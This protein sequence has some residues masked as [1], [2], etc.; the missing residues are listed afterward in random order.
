MDSSPAAAL[1]AERRLQPIKRKRLVDSLEDSDT[2]KADRKS[3][4]KFA[5]SPRVPPR[6]IV[7]GKARNSESRAPSARPLKI[8]QS[9]ATNRKLSMSPSLSMSDWQ[10]KGRLKQSNGSTNERGETGAFKPKEV[11]T[12]EAF[13]IDFCNSNGCPTA[14][15]DLMVQ[16][17]KEGSFPGQEW[18]KKKNFWQNVHTI[19]PNRDR[20]SVYRF[21]KRHFQASG[22]KPHEWTNEQEDELVAL[23]QQYGPKW[24]V[25]AEMLG[26]SSDDVVQRWKNRL[27][28][29]ATMNTGPWSE[30]ELSALQGALQSAWTKMKAESYDVGR[31]IYEMDESLISWGAVSD[32]MEHSRSRQQCADKW[33]RLK[34]K[35][36]RRSMS[37]SNSRNTTPLGTP[38]TE[39]FTKELQQLKNYKSEAYVNFDTDDSDGQEDGA[40]GSGKKSTT[41]HTTMKQ[42]TKEPHETSKPPSADE[43]SKHSDSDESDSSSSSSSAS[44]SETEP[45][46]ESSSMLNNKSKP[47]SE[48][49]SE[50]ESDSSA[51]PTAKSNEKKTSK[52]TATTTETTSSSSGSNSDSDSDSSSDS[53]ESAQKHAVPKV[54]G[55]SNELTNSHEASDSSSEEEGSDTDDSERADTASAKPQSAKSAI[56]EDPHSTKRKR[57]RSPAQEDRNPD[58]KR[59]KVKEPPSPTRSETSSESS[60]ESEGEDDEEPT[61]GGKSSAKSSSSDSSSE[62]DAESD[63]SESNVNTESNINKSPKQPTPSNSTASSD[64][65]S[66]DSEDEHKTEV[67]GE[68]RVEK[69]GNNSENDTR[70]SSSSGSDSSDSD[71]DN[72]DEDNEGSIEL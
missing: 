37:Q 46:P 47:D 48:Y 53:S 71:S 39:R 70:S 26:R 28:H 17:G 51:R 24:A 10:A 19:L 61:E 62:S 9:T 65:D 57:E 27:E 44:E 52:A 11:E 69:D 23:Y 15:F 12:L 60:S 54:T 36:T 18:I 59:S 41:T 22:Q 38:R 34:S 4:S 33:R 42:A 7:G 3:G 13:K 55:I 56:E 68:A 16:H 2:P 45:K 50:D 64:S 5:D 29:R 49:S 30:Q 20:R 58:A 63:A 6:T 8:S 66:S 72:D 43:K 67:S 40:D 14:T 1:S 21:M 31:D 32:S 25:L 35:F